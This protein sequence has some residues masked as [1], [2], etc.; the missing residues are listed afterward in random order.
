MLWKLNE[1]NVYSVQCQSE[2]QRY[3]WIKSGGKPTQS[4]ARVLDSILM[5]D[6][7]QEKCTNLLS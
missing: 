3:G 7:E 1:F 5:A 2:W 4:L 6:F